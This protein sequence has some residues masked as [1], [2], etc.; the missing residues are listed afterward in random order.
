MRSGQKKVVVFRTGYTYRI[1]KK[2][3][4]LMEGLEKLKPKLVTESTEDPEISR[5][6]YTD[7]VRSSALFINDELWG[8]GYHEIIGTDTSFEGYEKSDGPYQTPEWSS[9]QLQAIFYFVKEKGKEIGTVSSNGIIC[10]SF[11]KMKDL[12]KIHKVVSDLDYCCFNNWNTYTN[13]SKVVFTLP[14]G[15]IW[16]YSFDTESG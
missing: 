15:K 6:Y 8:D 13:K 2:K 12:K 5:E 9:D 7:G 14:G 11:D 4:Q 3:I 16:Y 10:F 1:L